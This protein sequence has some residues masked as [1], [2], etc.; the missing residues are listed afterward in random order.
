VRL[1]PYRHERLLLVLI[2]LATLVP[3][4]PR[5]TQ[6]E[7]RMALSQAIIAHGSFAIDWY[8]YTN[9][10]ARYGG[11]YYTDKAPG[12]SFAAIPAVAV[13]RAIDKAHDPGHIRS[14]RGRWHRYPLR[15]LFGGIPFLVTVFLV[16]RVAE[17]L[18][19]GTG[20]FTAAVFGLG[21]LFAPLAAVI[22]G[23]V[24][25]GALGFGAFLLATRGRAGW[26]GF[27][28]GCAVL[29]EY[30]SG[31][32]ALALLAYVAAQGLEPAARYVLA[33]LPPAILLGFYDAVAFGSPLHLSYRYVANDYT[34]SQQSG[35]FGIHAP[36]ASDVRAVLIGG[37]GTSVG[38]GL[39]ITSP[40][41][42]ACVAGLV[43]LWRRGLRWEAG[44]ALFVGAAYFVYTAGYFL[45]Y[46]GT[47]PGPRFF[48]PALPFLV[49]GL[50]DALRRWPWPTA[51]LG[52]VSV[53]VMTDNSLAWFLNDR[54]R[55]S[56]LPET[57]WSNLGAP[58]EVGV[59][60]VCAAALAA[61]A[62]ATSAL[63][64]TA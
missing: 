15:L 25:A 54:L 50:P 29:S 16:G 19:S 13:V 61:A 56:V 31:I 23:H 18:R 58:T 48:A 2:A 34:K 24:F 5:S 36:T 12:I 37:S 63:R 46:G 6:E 32:V 60:L 43:L 40:V 62:V 59:A 27:L 52:L 28:A 9:D 47:S 64:R 21:T 57:L 22:F 55:L 45:A 20:A 33:A 7:T 11:R 3:M 8:G 49:L 10:R 26:A 42:I 38:R 1:V 41:L 44:I 17:G 53:A 35:F 14:W 51:A 39:L 4:H 30:Q